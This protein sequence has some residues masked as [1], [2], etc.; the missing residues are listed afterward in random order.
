MM[1][2]FESIGI[3]L[4]AHD[5]YEHFKVVVQAIAGRQNLMKFGV[6]AVVKVPVY[7]YTYTYPPFSIEHP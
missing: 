7:I 4:R 1:Q 5:R 3:S 2:S 6:H